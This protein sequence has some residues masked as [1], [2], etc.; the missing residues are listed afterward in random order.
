MKQRID[1]K[2][3][4]DIQ[5]S[6]MDQV[7]AFCT[8]EGI[9]YSLSGGSLLGAVRHKGFIPWDD[10]V[11]LMMPRPDY[12]RFLSSFNDCHDDIKAL[13]YRVDANFPRPFTKITDLNTRIVSRNGISCY[14]V[15]L[16]VFPIDGQPSTEEETKVY[17]DKY[18]I[19]NKWFYKKTPIYRMTGNPLVA[20]KTLIRAPFY[21]SRDITYRQIRELIEAYPFESS[22]YAG[23]IMGDSGMGTHIPTKVFYDFVRREFEGRQYSTIKDADTYLTRMYG[24]YMTPPPPA[25][26]RT[27]HFGKVYRIK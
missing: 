9:N 8:A 25:Q 23:A 14:G 24:D 5:L 22:E 2:G 17:V 7:D 20:L 16:D 19:L 6:M 11:D 12:E 15:F 18:A 13:N 1:A 10:D 4:R 26:Q 21:P 3:L 27:R